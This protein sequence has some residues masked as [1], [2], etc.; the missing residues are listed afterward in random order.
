MRL[1]LILSLAASC[2][3][4]SGQNL[5]LRGVVTDESGGVV[6]GATVTLN[7]PAA[8]ARTA[9]T[10]NAGAYSFTGVPPGAYEVRVTA[11]GLTLPKPLTIELNTGAQTLDL[12]LAV[13]TTT[14]EVTVSDTAAQ[15]VSTDASS[16]TNALVLQGDDLQSLADNS[17]DLAADLQALAGPSAGPNGG[18]IYVDGFSGGDLPSKESIREI[19]VNQ[20]PF[21][22]EYD[23]LG[24]GR[25][26]IFTKPGLDKFKGT[27]Y[28]NFGNDFWNA[29]NPYAEQKAPLHLYEYGGSLSGPIHKRASFFLDIRRDSI[30]NGA[31]INGT[32]LDPTTLA[33]VN[34]YTQVFLVP[35]R[36]ITVS[37][38]VDYQINEH[39]TLSVRYSF[40]NSEV[41]YIG[42]GGFNLVSR[43]Y[44]WVR[45][46]HDLDV[47]ETAVLGSGIVNETRFEFYHP[48][49]SN[50]AND[51]SPAV[52]VLGS[53]NGGGAQ[54]GHTSQTENYYEVQ[55]NTSILKG[56]QTWRFGV[57][58]REDRVSSVSPQN[59]GG[60]YTFGGGLG[61]QL[62]ANNQ[63]VLDPSGS[64]V[65]VSLDS[66]VRYQRTLAF[67]Q[68]GLPPEQIRALGGGATQFSINA[69]NP[70]LSASRF[71]VGAFV[72]DDWRARPNLTLS[73]GLRFEGQTNIHDWRDF[74]PRFGLAWAP[75]GGSRK[76]AP[77]TVI[78]AGFGIFYDRFSL[79]NTINAERYDG[80]TVQQ[81]V[82]TNP[83]FFPLVP[84]A[85]SLTGSKAASPIQEISSTLR[86]PYVMQ[87]A[88]SVERQLPRNTTIAVTYANTHGL[89]VL[90]SQDVNAPLLGTYNPLVPGS[91]VYPLGNPGP[92]F[93][94]ESSGLYN[95][96]QLITNVNSRVNKKISLFGSFLVNHALSNT[97]G[98][99]TFPARPYTFEGDYGPAATDIRY[100]T[101]LGGSITTWWDIRLNP[102]LTIDSGT[103][104][105]ITVG[106]DLY[107]TT[108]FNARPALATDPT[109]PGLIETA[110]GLLD[111]NPAFNQ[112]TLPRNYGRGPGS[113]LFNVRVGKTFSFGRG[114]GHAAPTNIPGGGPQSQSNAGVFNTAGSSGGAART[115][116]RYNLTISMAV[117]NI[118]NHP[119]PGPIIGNITS[120]L[121][122]NANQIAGVNSTGFSEAANNRRLELQTR[123]TF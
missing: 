10:N 11:P 33:V 92:V 2:S 6:P 79:A 118:L 41:P 78:R 75:G 121:F 97:D 12:V 23:K 67:I 1:L 71:D 38:R 102:L 20:N 96:N 81:Y 91:G 89:H 52:L 119:N 40:V 58:L 66:I 93:L 18:S 88:L 63:P 112:P 64:P 29:R 108:L 85:S 109:K 74:A 111:P 51:M 49:N 107:G 35:Q 94:M 87:S 90:R 26:E 3:Q 34:P 39:H 62:D 7:N 68:M 72:G 43:G 17:E 31:I 32:V 113:I 48:D 19:R 106:R 13:A 16:N 103:P 24:F 59:F 117:R 5:S 56:S 99:I 70:A 73:A 46:G 42:I 15:T 110:Y 54:I 105:D 45:N 83:D 50:V 30:D 82:V 25:I 100:R 98:L 120:P 86:A 57:R 9:R 104:F 114:E 116:H 27:L 44:D 47:T 61:P 101:S 28:Y 22:P 55:N 36:R 84:P 122:G 37:P 77:K 123:F 95:Q 14:E 65:I 4:L 80:V 60:T 53:F 115:S 69:G 8:R 76:S 21:S